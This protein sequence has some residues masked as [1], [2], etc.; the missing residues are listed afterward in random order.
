MNDRIISDS[1]ITSTHINEFFLNISDG[2]LLRDTFSY[3][4]HLLTTYDKVPSIARILTNS[5]EVSNIIDS[6]NGSASNGYDKISVNF[7]K[8]CKS[9]LY[10]ILA[11]L[12]N[13]HFENGIFPDE[14]KIARVKPI[15]KGGAPIP[16]LS[17]LSNVFESVMKMNLEG[18]FLESAIIN[19]SQFDVTNRSSTLS[20]YRHVLS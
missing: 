19:E 8:R 2:L 18:H 16:V 7:L 17:S 10:P 3:P 15:F 20:P 1:K 9:K 4:E 5:Q 12:I 11:N 13:D 6:R 14:L